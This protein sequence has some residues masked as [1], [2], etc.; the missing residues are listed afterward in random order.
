MAARAVSSQDGRMSKTDQLRRPNVGP[1]RVP[2]GIPQR[3]ASRRPGC[4]LT[5]LRL[6]QRG[7]PFVQLSLPCATE[8]KSL[9]GFGAQRRRNTAMKAERLN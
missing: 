3:R 5:P 4:Q 1:L 8:N 7:L 6:A 2:A 9:A